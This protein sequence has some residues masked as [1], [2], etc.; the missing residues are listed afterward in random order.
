MEKII[1]DL[2]EKLTEQRDSLLMELRSMDESRVNYHIKKTD[3]TIEIVNIDNRIDG[4]LNKLPLP[5]IHSQ[6]NNSK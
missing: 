4:Y 6:T 5:V 1:S 2:I 3:I